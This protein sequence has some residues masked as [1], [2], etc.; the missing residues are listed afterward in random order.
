VFKV[1]GKPFTAVDNIS[2]GIP[3]GE[4]FGLLGVNG[5][6][7]TTTF[8]MLTGDLPLSSGS[9]TIDGYDVATD[10]VNVRRRIGYCPQYNGLV[11][12]L[13]GRETLCFFARLR[14]CVT[15]CVCVCACVCACVCVYLCV[16]VC[17][18]VCGCVC[19]CV[20]MYVY[21]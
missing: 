8:R 12:L 14:G 4:C 17:V 16:C 3:S 10:L 1:A 9:I 6:G 21:M 20:C 15:V 19:V 18:C 2:V 7:K 5:A 13:T 11:E